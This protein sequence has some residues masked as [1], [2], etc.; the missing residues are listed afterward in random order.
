VIQQKIER[1]RDIGKGM[2]VYKTDIWKALGKAVLCVTTNGFVKEDGSGV[3]GAGIAKQ[4]KERFPGIEYRLG[5]HLMTKGNCVGIIW[6]NP[7]LCSFPV[8]PT[9]MKITSKHQL[10]PHMRDKIKLNTNAPGWACVASLDLIR[11]SAQELFDLTEKN[12][13]KHVCLTKPGCYNG[14][15]RWED[16][17]P[18]LDGIFD[19]RFYIIDRR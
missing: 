3:M 18:I 11:L 10:V 13:W 17:E 4:A 7:I 15:L 9:I 16:V 1:Y 8:K 6:E 19:E 5:Y 14:N 2:K 12:S